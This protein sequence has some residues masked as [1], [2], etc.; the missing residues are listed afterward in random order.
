LKFTQ[1]GYIKLTCKYNR[2]D[3]MFEFSVEDTGIGIKEE[4]MSLLFVLFGK[5][6]R[7]QELNNQGIGLGLNICK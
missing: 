4:D 5:L 7:N 2:E 6:K 1:K 3:S